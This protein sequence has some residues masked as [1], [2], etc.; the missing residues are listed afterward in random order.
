MASVARG[1]IVVA[2]AAVAVAAGVSYFVHQGFSSRPAPTAAEALIA[3]SLRAAAIP[4]KYKDM[5]NP[6]DCS[7][8]VF[9]E[10]SAHWADHCATCHANNGAGDSM[11]G[12]TMYPRPPDMRLPATQ[13]QSDG[14]L[15]Y[16]INSGVRLTGMPAFGNPGDNDTASW[17]LICFIR[18]IPKLTPE[19]IDGLKALNPKTPEDLEEERQEKEFLNGG[20][21]PGAETSTGHKH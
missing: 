20:P 5:R 19:E 10:A 16:T 1:F 18:R 11:L 4:G 9:E 13:N 21:L 6:V 12:K 17:K 7:P 15:Y 2:V 8:Q 14:E 3:T